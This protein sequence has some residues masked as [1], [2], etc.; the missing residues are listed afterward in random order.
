MDL[1]G[2]TGKVSKKRVHLLRW[3]TF[4]GRT[5]WNFGWIDRVQ[6]LPKLCAV[7]ITIKKRNFMVKEKRSSGHFCSHSR[8]LQKITLEGWA[9]TNVLVKNKI[10]LKILRAPTIHTFAHKFKDMFIT[11]PLQSFHRILIRIKAGARRFNQ[12][13][14]CVLPRE[15]VYWSSTV[16]REIP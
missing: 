1:F 10:V 13:D 16:P 4:P 3:T 15:A 14:Y 2:P 7:T 8:Q 12:L 9:S 6:D 11:W 5:S